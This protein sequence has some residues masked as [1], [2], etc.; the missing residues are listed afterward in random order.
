MNL[1]PVETNAPVELVP[2]R[3][4][5]NFH[6]A[7]WDP[8]IV[9]SKNSERFDEVVAVFFIKLNSLHQGE[10][11]V[12]VAQEYPQKMGSA[13]SLRTLIQCRPRLYAV[14][15][16]LILKRQKEISVSLGLG[17]H[18]PFLNLIAASLNLTG[19]SAVLGGFVLLRDLSPAAAPAVIS[20]FPIGL[21]LF[22]LAAFWS[23]GSKNDSRLVDAA[24]ASIRRAFFE[25]IEKLKDL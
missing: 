25:L 11:V 4:K 21:T 19:L 13:V 16:V 20:L 14:G 1:T 17:S 8:A 24:H 2:V 6:E 12:G 23:R 22:C 5:A 7:R 15:E 18:R 9:V 10:G 3:E